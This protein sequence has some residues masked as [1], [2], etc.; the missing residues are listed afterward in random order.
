[1]LYVLTMAV[2]QSFS[3]G[4]TGAM[5]PTAPPTRQTAI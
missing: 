3:D 1:M 2:A 5:A 4:E